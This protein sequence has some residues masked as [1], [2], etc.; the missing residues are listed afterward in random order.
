[1]RDECYLEITIHSTR[2][3][4]VSRNQFSSVRRKFLCGEPFADYPRLSSRLS[5][6]P[7]FTAFLC[8][9]RVQ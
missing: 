4:L 1:M 2:I 5:V 9:D 3:T 6:S 8:D 7:E